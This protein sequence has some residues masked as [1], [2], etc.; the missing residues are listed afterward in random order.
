MSR[1]VGAIAWSVLLG[2][3]GSGPTQL[4][5][6]GTWQLTIAYTTCTSQNLDGRGCGYLLSLGGTE[7]LT[8]AQTGVEVTGT[9][10]SFAVLQ[11]RLNGDDLLLDGSG[12]NPGTRSVV[13]QHWRLRVSADRMTGTVSQTHIYAEGLPDRS[14]PGTS[15]MTG[16]VTK[17][18]RQP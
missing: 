17:G 8:L 10:A 6:T 4:D 15:A 14:S 11:G 18:V 3:C 12:T 2:S 16:D 7:T 13:T 9:S 1:L 5:V